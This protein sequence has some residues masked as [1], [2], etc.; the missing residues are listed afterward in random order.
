MAVQTIEQ[1]IKLLKIPPP[2][3]SDHNVILG[4]LEGLP[5]LMEWPA[6]DSEREDWLIAG[7]TF[8]FVVPRRA[9]RARSALRKRIVAIGSST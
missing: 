6:P 7:A 8:L 9:D 3:D 2:W 1:A 4:G 5:T